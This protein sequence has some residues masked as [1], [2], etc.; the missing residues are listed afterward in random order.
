MYFN[1]EICAKCKGE[2]CK[3]SG[4]LLSTRDIRGI[5]TINKFLERKAIVISSISYNSFMMFAFK[6]TDSLHDFIRLQH[7]QYMIKAIQLKKYDNV[8]LIK[9][10]S[11][12]QDVFE[13]IDDPNKVGEKLAS[14]KCVFL[15]KNGCKL[16]DTKRP[17]GGLQLE[18][19]IRGIKYCKLHFSIIDAALEWLEFHEELDKIFEK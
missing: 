2:C 9:T 8:Y 11:K 1:K 14:G 19:N 13:T 17:Y 4:C 6:I 18:P 12:N 5:D 7:N 15:G 16:S 3:Q 10:R